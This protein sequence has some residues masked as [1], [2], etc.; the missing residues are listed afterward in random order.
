MRKSALLRGAKVG[1]KRQANQET[2][3]TQ[4]FLKKRNLAIIS[5]DKNHE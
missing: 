1:K 3:Q 2:E 4:N 5:K